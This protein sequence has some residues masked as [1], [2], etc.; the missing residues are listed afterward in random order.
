MAQGTQCGSACSNQVQ[1]NT[2]KSTT[3]RDGG[4]NA[5]LDFDTGLGV[6]PVE[7]STELVITLRSG[8]DHVRIGKLDAGN[9]SLYTIINQTAEMNQDPF[10]GISGENLIIN[11]EL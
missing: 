1:Y 10:S 6:K 3:F 7:S 11:Q 5:T 4:K 8:S 9:T 2:S